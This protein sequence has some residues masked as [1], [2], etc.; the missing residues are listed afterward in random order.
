MTILTLTGDGA[1]KYCDPALNVDVQ[2]KDLIRFWKSLD[3]KRN[4][5]IALV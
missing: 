2:I 4:K 1:S 5:N 3:L